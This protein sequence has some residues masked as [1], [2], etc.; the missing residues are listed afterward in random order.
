MANLQD[1]TKVEPNIEDVLKVIK[2]D[3]FVFDDIQHHFNCIE[4]GLNEFGKDFF[5]SEEFRFHWKK[6]INYLMYF[7]ILDKPKSK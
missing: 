1:V 2:N 4:H 5:N 3:Y 6:M 7:S